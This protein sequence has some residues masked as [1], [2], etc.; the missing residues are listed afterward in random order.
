MPTFDS[1]VERLI[2]DRRFWSVVLLGGALCFVPVLNIFAFGYL[3]AYAVQ[4]RRR[5]DLRLPD[6][7][8]WDILFIDGLRFLTIWLLFVAAP[9]IVAAIMGWLMTLFMGDFVKPTSWLLFSL[10]VVLAPVWF[11]IM[12]ERFIQRGSL[13][14]LRPRLSDLGV[15]RNLLSSFWLP[16]FAMIGIAVVAAPLYGFVL[17]ASHLLFITYTFLFFAGK[18]HGVVK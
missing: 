13:A 10:T 12:L 17:F 5:G 4:V 1:I 7:R 14:D 6:W 2:A 11:V 9:L 15:V 3:Y 16:L 8:G 18:A